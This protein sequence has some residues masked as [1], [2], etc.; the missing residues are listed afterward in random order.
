MLSN[1]YRPLVTA[2]AVVAI[3]WLLAWG[4]YTV[5]RNSKV[6]ADKIRAFVQK[7]DLRKLSGRDRQKALRNLAVKINALSPEERR[8]PGWNGSGP[9]GSRP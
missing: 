9:T 6:T 1:R 8:R 4:G 3:A 5:A 7:T 2:A